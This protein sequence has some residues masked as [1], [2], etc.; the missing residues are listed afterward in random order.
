MAKA[1]KAAKLQRRK[2]P[3]KPKQVSHYD[4]CEA[5]WERR[6]AERKAQ[7]V[8][9][10]AASGK[11][12]DGPDDWKP[13]ARFVTPDPVTSDKSG[14]D[15]LVDRL[16]LPAKPVPF[17]ATLRSLGDHLQDQRCH[18][19]LREWG[20]SNLIDWKTGKWSRHGLT[21]ANPQT[22]LMCELIEETIATRGFKEREAIA[23]AVKELGLDAP[24]FRTACKRV[25]RLLDAY[26]KAVGQDPP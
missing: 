2:P 1:K 20:K 9:A 26:R 13:G 15:W 5:E 3:S 25:K 16:E 4:K 8:E 6:K 10:Q 11:P 17:L 19:L 18:D 21:L 24:S 12:D 23:D 7:F 14:G 22:R